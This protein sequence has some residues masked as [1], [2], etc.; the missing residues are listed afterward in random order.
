M[1][2]DAS[3]LPSAGVLEQRGA[4]RL[5]RLT[6]KVPGLD[7]RLAQRLLL[8]ARPALGPVLL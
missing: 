1:P 8:R 5:S 4:V 3:R 7:G 2:R 6:W